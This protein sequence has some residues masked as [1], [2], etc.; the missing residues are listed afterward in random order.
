[1]TPSR[2]FVSAGPQQA[3]QII[4]SVPWFALAEL[5]D[6]RRRR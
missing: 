6:E 3:S 2:A 1:V 5:F 4:S